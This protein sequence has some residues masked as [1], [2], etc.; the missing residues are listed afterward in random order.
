MKVSGVATLLL[1]ASGASSAQTTNDP[2]LVV[3][4][5]ECRGNRSTSCEFI[6][7]HL[8]LAAG[9][10]VD[11]AEIRNAQLRLSS[12]RN[13]E[14]VDVRLQRGTQR[15]AAIVV[16]EVTEASLITTESVAGLSSRLDSTRSVFAT[17]VAHHNL[18]GGGET[19]DLSGVAVTP[20]AGDAHDEDYQVHLRYADPNLFGA[21][22]F[23]GI[24]RLSWMNTRRQDIY[25]NFSDFEGP[26]I[27]LRVGHRFG[28]FS[29]VTFGATFRPKLD[30][31]TGEWDGPGDFDVNV[32]HNHYGLNIIYGWNTEDDLYFPTR[33]HSFH[34]GAGWDFGSGSPANR[35][36]I[37][38][39]KTWHVN[40]GLLTL[41]LGGSPSPEYR[42]SFEE[43]Q[44]LSVSYSQALQASDHLKRGRWYVEPGVGYTAGFTPDGDRI[45]E[46]G[47][48]AGVRLDTTSFGIVDLYL[49]G[50]RDPQR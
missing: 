19:I 1:L 36:H 45:Y 31:T 46:V 34:V 35:S 50:T 13:F 30:F 33:G 25:G 22:H 49:M 43:S 44:L 48:K 2:P 18:F 21:D 4:S 38:Y 10:P 28:A 41:K 32:R 27:D 8:N 7:S 42:T 17:R 12:V 16:I 26:E 37:Q 14:A 29:Y 20:F 47:I 24:A 40:D 15:A 9:M 11:E 5:V 3:Q 23:F 6:R 39:R